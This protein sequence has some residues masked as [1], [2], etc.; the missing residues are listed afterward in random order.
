MSL[1]LH[2]GCGTVYLEEFVNIDS[3]GKYIDYGRDFSVHCDD[4]IDYQK[5]Y[6]TSEFE[7]NKTVL[8][9]YYK[10][11]LKESM[12]ANKVVI[13]DSI[14]DIT[15][16]KKL[17]ESGIGNG[18]VDEIVSVQVLEQ[19]EEHKLFP[20]LTLWNELLHKDGSMLVSVPDARE[21][22]TYIYE[23]YDCLNVN[24]DR[25]ALIWGFRLLYGSRQNRHVSW[26][27]ENKLKALLLEA[28]FS[29]IDKSVE[30]KHDYPALVVRC[31]K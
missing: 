13:V 4:S 29:R 11:D 14:D 25:E 3:I 28:G 1:R 21:T 15:E 16:L 9:S 31:Y 10:N 8:S 23:C 19:I 5:T 6:A 20:T 12:K 30:I 24:K 7:A 2:L 27:D 18:M 26:F 22:V 17:K